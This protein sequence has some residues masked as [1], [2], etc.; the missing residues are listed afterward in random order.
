MLLVSAGVIICPCF[1]L[2]LVQG[3]RKNV[4]SLRLSLVSSFYP[5]PQ[6]AGGC[7][8]RSLGMYDSDVGY[9]RWISGKLYCSDTVHHHLLGNPWFKFFLWFRNFVTLGC[10]TLVKNL[11]TSLYTVQYSTINISCHDVLGESP[12]FTT[13]EVL[14]C[15]TIAE[16]D[17]PLLT[18]LLFL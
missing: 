5:V 15:C 2:I 7:A 18:Q 11:R 13:E 12:W 9:V 1:H 16:T 6:A 14:L 4:C 10:G 3:W 17:L 8:W